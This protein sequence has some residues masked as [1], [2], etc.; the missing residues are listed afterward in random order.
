VHELKQRRSR[1]DGSA[2]DAEGSAALDPD[3]R[4]RE[5]QR[6]DVVAD[7]RDDHATEADLEA[8][9]RDRAADGRDETAEAR[10]A[11]AGASA[12]SDP[13]PEDRRD[14]RKDRADAARDR[15]NARKDRS[16]AGRDRS[17]SK[18]ERDRASD[19]RG[20]AGAAMAEVRVLLAGAEENVEDMLLVGRAQGLIMHERQLPPTAAL[21]QL[22]AEASR[23]Q[24]SLGETSRT[25]VG[26]TS[27]WPTTPPENG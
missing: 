25:I 14:A 24:A 6:Q 19:D 1:R 17:T 23:N 16:R 8:D 13:F 11:D 15:R 26:Q 3:E 21:L 12:T 10:D 27:R 4:D 2:D 18:Q 5:S 7:A 20:A 9:A 22:C